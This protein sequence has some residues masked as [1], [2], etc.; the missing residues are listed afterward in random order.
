[1]EGRKGKEIGSRFPVEG[2]A[3]FVA[4]SITVFRTLRGVLVEEKEGILSSD[5]RRVDQA[6][7]LKEE[8]VVRIRGLEEWRSTL[9]KEMGT[10]LRRDPA[11]LTLSD[12]L[13]V[14]P[15]GGS[16][17][18]RASLSTLSGLLS[19]VQ[20]TNADIRCLIL[21]TLELIRG[22]ISL[23]TGLLNGHG[24]YQKT[25]TIGIGYPAGKLLSKAL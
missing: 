13:V 6:N 21:G 7:Q 24:V 11:S 19:E 8:L 17:E 3:R 4:E 2:L 10:C 25:G 1:M 5:A 15:V 22:S 20:K 14:E 9:W 12:L 16:L 18:F 23:L